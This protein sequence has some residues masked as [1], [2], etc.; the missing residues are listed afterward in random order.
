MRLRWVVVAVPGAQTESTEWI[1]IPINKRGSIYD[2]CPDFFLTLPPSIIVLLDHFPSYSN[3]FLYY[4][5]LWVLI[6]YTI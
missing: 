3:S 6:L 4:L 5:R 1:Q 2:R